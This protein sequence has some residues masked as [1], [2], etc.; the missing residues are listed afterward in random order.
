[1]HLYDNLYAPSVAVWIK[2]LICDQ[3]QD[4]DFEG[5]SLDSTVI[6]QLPDLDIDLRNDLEN[7]K[8]GFWAKYKNPVWNPSI[9]QSV[10]TFTDEPLLIP[11]L[12]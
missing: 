12:I 6:E 1:M 10:C 11:N 9:C 5:C 7:G 4:L 2:H 8:F 3:D